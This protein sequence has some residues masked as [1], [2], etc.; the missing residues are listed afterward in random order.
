MEEKIKIVLDGYNESAVNF[1]SP[2]HI[3]LSRSLAWIASKAVHSVRFEKLIGER[4]GG[5]ATEQRESVSGI[6]DF[7]KIQRKALL[8]FHLKSLT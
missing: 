3:R 1:L 4:G 6:L 2:H 7:L 5:T 8:T